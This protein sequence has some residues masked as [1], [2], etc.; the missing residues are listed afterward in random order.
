MADK[1]AFN[2]IDSLGAP[3]TNATPTFL[4]YKTK[5]G[6]ALS[7]PTITP[8]STIGGGVY[9]FTPT[10]ADVAAGVAYLI[11]A[12]AGAFPRYIAGA[13]FLEGSPFLATMLIDSLGGLWSGLPPSVGIYKDFTGA[14]RTPPSLTAVGGAYFYTLIPSQADFVVGTAYRIDAPT[15][16]AP[17]YASGSFYPASGPS[18]PTP[19]PVL[20]GFG[21][22]EDT[23]QGL[24]VD[25][26]QLDGSKVIWADQTRTRPE[27]PFVELAVLDDETTAFTED[28]VTETAGS[29]VGEEITLSS[30]D[31]NELTV[32]AR[33]FSG[34]VTGDNCAM[35]MARKIRKFFG[36]ESTQSNLGEIALV[37]RDTVRGA[38]L[39]L[40]TEFEG[41]A[42][43]A[44]KF[45]VAEVETETTT[46]IEVVTVQTTVSQTNG[47]VIYTSAIQLED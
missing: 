36:R 28:D 13:V 12:G 29:P 2:L 47:D 17:K 7:A 31:H 1:I 3:K 24:V 30:K 38:N 35:N 40:E 33:C 44:L 25:A 43:L 23:I 8:G 5:T 6:G 41:R 46:F 39:R 32:Q 42:L 11:D 20:S 26:L 14:G 37:S 18:A 9:G 34:E 27:R 15:G 4:V 22:F 21:D 16:A 19:P 45:R 10:D